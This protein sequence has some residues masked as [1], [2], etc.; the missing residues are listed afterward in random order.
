MPIIEMHLLKGRT[1][2]QKRSAA[3]AITQALAAT[4]GVRPEQV[5]ILIT[6]HGA[7]DFSVGGVTAAE[8]AAIEGRQ[9]TP[10]MEG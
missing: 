7:E 1:V 6:E 5:R 9:M 8:R 3:A 4:L 2:E 10:S